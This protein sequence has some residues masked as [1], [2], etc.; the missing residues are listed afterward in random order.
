MSQNSSF[1]PQGPTVLVG[2]SV[3]QAAANDNVTPTTYRVRCL[4]AGYF[5]W[6][7]SQG[8]VAPAITVVA[9]VD[10]VPSGQTIGMAVG[11][12]ETFILAQ[13]CYFKASVA[14][15]FEVTPGEG[16]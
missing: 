14:A 1:Q 2:T 5:S 16:M 15:A 4:V 11:Q 3:V 10:G 7:S 12:C 6:A 9:P 8:P 13:N